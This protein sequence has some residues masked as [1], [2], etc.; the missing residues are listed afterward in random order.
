M[1]FYPTAN[2]DQVAKLSAALIV[3][4]I[5]ESKATPEKPFVLGLPTGSTPVKTYKYLIE[6]Y[7]AGEISFRNVITFN[8]D[9]YVGLPKEHPQSYWTFMHQNLFDH[10]DM[11]PENINILD[12]CTSNH[13]EEC[14]RYEKK[15]IECGGIDFFLGGIG[16]DGHI[17]FNE[18]YSSLH[19]RT[20][21]KFLNTITRNANARFF[22]DDPEKVPKS[23]LTI[24]VGTLSDSKEICLMATGSSKAVAVHKAIEG[25]VNHQWT[26][27]TIQHHRCVHLMVDEL[28]TD[29]LKW[30][31]LKY[32]KDIEGPILNQLEEGVFLTKFNF[33]TYY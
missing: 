10:I 16:H 30:K 6:L 27:S 4:R 5:L 3:T 29:E 25:P 15:I 28:A 22:D 7:Q 11:K 13:H 21:L 23:A 32:F 19:S 2:P 18:P 31:T 26:V 33:Q 8:M 20:R 1:R 24:G 17:A 12:G 9:E 14:E